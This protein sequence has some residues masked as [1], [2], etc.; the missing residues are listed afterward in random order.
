MSDRL[1]QLLTSAEATLADLQTAADHLTGL[2]LQF[3]RQIG[4]IGQELTLHPEF[5]PKVRE[6]V[7]RTAP[8]VRMDSGLSFWIHRVYDAA[9][10]RSSEVQDYMVALAMR[11][12]IEF[13]RDLYRN[14]AAAHRVAGI[15]TDETDQDL[16][17]WSGH[18]YITEIPA[19]IPQ[20]HVWW[21]QS[22]RWPP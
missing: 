8:V 20:S 9:E 21:Y 4:D 17:E 5:A 18:Q 7:E 14:S 13:F 22:R 3:G 19:G 10:S 12:E 16:K 15:E 11:S 1:D 2:A 6:F